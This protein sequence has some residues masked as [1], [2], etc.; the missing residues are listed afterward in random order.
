M[1]GNGY[2][3]QELN[4]DTEFFGLRCARVRIF[5][6]LDCIQFSRL[7]KGI[8]DYGFVTIDNVI[9]S[10]DNNR[11]L[12]SMQGNY[13]VDVPLTFSYAL[14]SE[15]RNVS[16]L[17]IFVTNDLPAD[18]KIEFIA[19]KSFLQGR[20]YKDPAIDHSAADDLY[21]SWIRNAFLRKDK[22]FVLDVERNGFI[23]FSDIEQ[24]H[25]LEIE[26]IAVDDRVRKRGIAGKMITALKAYAVEKGYRYIKVVTQADNIGAV[27]LYAHH[28]FK[29]IKCEYTYHFWNR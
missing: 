17:G 13:L 22:Y 12:C 15:D 2:E 29:L 6:D 28:R 11:V 10:G 8:Q 20:F 16:P 9:G 1:M 27:N 7:V 18:E 25:G 21:A 26:L 4:W 14:S 23:L 19:K 24:G 3:L 5:E